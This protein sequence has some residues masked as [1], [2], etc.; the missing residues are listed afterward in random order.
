MLCPLN[1]QL[2]AR[3]ANRKQMREELLK[4][5]IYIPRSQ[6]HLGEVMGDFLEA[7]CPRKNVYQISILQSSRTLYS[8][9]SYY[10]THLSHRLL[11]LF[12]NFVISLCCLMIY[13]RYLHVEI[14][15]V[16]VMYY[17]R[18]LCF[19]VPRRLHQQKIQDVLCCKISLKLL[20]K[21]Y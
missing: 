17:V 20:G 10:I 19:G 7:A 11:K 21:A 3:K 6:E 16:S 13:V 18:L 4:L 8:P 1:D 2:R 12:S 14:A 9:V 15:A 5:Y